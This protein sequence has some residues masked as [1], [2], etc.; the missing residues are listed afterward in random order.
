[1]GIN[2]WALK[3]CARNI[4]LGLLAMLIVHFVTR[5]YRELG[6]MPFSPT[7][8]AILAGLYLCGR[9]ASTL[10]PL[11]EVGADSCDACEIY[12]CRRP[13]IFTSVG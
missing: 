2:V 10:F 8:L 9:I 6:R 12:E 13:V 5:I 11:P 4:C 3:V 7:A 1:M